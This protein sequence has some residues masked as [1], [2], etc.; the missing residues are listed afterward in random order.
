MEERSTDQAGSGNWFSSTFKRPPDERGIEVIQTL[1]SAPI[2][3]ELRMRTL[4]RLAEYAHVRDYRMHETIYYDGDPGIGLYVIVRGRVA[5]LLEEADGAV[6]EI[7][8]AGP[9]EMFGELAV[10]GSTRRTESAQAATDARVIGLF[11][12]DIM[13]LVK[14]H[15]KSGSEIMSAF[16][17]MFARREAMLIQ[18]VSARDGR[19]AALR[20]FEGEAHAQELPN[21]ETPSA[22][23]P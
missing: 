7:R 6:H 22:I 14:R 11:R 2:F 19:L 23:K 5:M 1:R 16:A 9:G 15:P 12:P 10:L 20:L 21:E 3:E 17:H 4:R 18:K 8:V 13:S